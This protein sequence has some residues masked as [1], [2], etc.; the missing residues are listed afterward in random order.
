LDQNKKKRSKQKT[1][2][3]YFPIMV[4]PKRYFLMGN[5]I[6]RVWAKRAKPTHFFENSKNVSP[7]G[8]IGNF[9]YKFNDHKNVADK[10]G[11]QFCP[12]G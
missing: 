2:A 9:D 10:T 11:F 5:K 1:Q 4:C 6:L 7:S 12:L 8:Q 3:V